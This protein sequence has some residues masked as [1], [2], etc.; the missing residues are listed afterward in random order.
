MG[1]VVGRIVVVSCMT[2][3][4][5]TMNYVD[6]IGPLA[7]RF[8]PKNSQLGRDNINHTIG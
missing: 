2:G 5:L 4:S 3:R 8:L 6:K 1:L 7:N